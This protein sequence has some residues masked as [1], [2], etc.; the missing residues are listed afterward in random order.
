MKT[1]HI[2]LLRLLSPAL[3]LT[4][5]FFL[6]LPRPVIQDVQD[7]QEVKVVYQGET[8]R[9]TDAEREQLLSVLSTA[10]CHVTYLERKHPVQPIQITV[11]S[12]S[13]PIMNLVVLE[14]GDQPRCTC[15]NA[16]WTAY[17]VHRPEQLR[18]VI[19]PICQAAQARG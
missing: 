16:R 5:L 1:A 3:F 18:A 15:P 4:V 13:A 2:W 10:R 19:E 14:L 9:L 8:L 17:R 6:L 11:T 12:A 7:V